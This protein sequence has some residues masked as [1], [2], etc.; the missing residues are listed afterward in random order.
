MAEKGHKRR[1]NKEVAFS[2]NAVIAGCPAKLIKILGRR[3]NE[4]VS[5]WNQLKY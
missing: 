4:V 5:F 3:E 1:R 2:D